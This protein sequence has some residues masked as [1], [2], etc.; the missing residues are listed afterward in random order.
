MT[1][2]GRQRAWKLRALVWTL[3]L[4]GVVSSSV[5]FLSRSAPPAAIGESPASAAAWGPSA[6]ESAQDIELAWQ[7]PERSREG[8]RGTSVDL[9]SPPEC[10]RDDSGRWH[11]GRPPVDVADRTAATTEE[12]GVVEVLGIVRASF[13]WQMVGFV[14]AAGEARGLF[15][16]VTTGEWVW[17]RTGES[18]DGKDYAI[19]RLHVGL[20]RVA[21]D[22]AGAA[23]VRTAWA[24]VEDR[25]TGRAIELCT[26]EWRAMG[27]PRAELRLSAAGLVW[28]LAEGERAEDGPAS[29][30]VQTVDVSRQRVVVRTT[31]GTDPWQAPIVVEPVPVRWQPV[32]G[33]AQ[34]GVAR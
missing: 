28:V 22:V 13:P 4:A 23:S 8:R 12:A 15:R 20:D 34:E 25:R 2:S 27:E 29:V 11:R 18:L 30:E 16:N 6:E 31:R 26:R 21:T 32:S 5:V 17:R 10:W 9:F 24:E 1:R 3:T 14:A 19:Q 33:E 7:W